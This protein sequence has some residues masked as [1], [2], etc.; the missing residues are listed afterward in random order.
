MVMI[1]AV[2][3][4]W[5]L[6]YLAQRTLEGKNGRTLD[7]VLVEE[8]INK[9]DYVTSSGGVISVDARVDLQV[10]INTFPREKLYFLSFQKSNRESFFDNPHKPYSGI[11]GYRE[12]LPVPD[13]MPH[14]IQEKEGRRTDY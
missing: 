9:T 4:V 6:A 11:A 2:M 13:L 8:L 1:V 3:F 7:S 10:K 12:G 14:E 5:T